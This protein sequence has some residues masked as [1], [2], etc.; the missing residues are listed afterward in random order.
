MTKIE[1]KSVSSSNLVAVGYDEEEKLLHV[2][3]KN[4]NV[5]E[6]RGV[7]K[8]TYQNLMGAESLGSYFHQNIK[9]GFPYSKV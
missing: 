3:F 9:F 5:Y 7:P 2:Q 8:K 1:M 4:G 6:Y